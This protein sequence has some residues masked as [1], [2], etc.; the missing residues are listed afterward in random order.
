M[1]YK[2][3]KILLASISLFAMAIFCYLAYLNIFVF[4]TMPIYSDEYGYALDLKAFF[5]THTLIS[6]LTLDELYSKVGNFSFH[7]FTYTLIYA[8]L[9]YL[10]F[11][12]DILTINVILSLLSLFFILV[13]IKEVKL[14]WKLILIGTYI[15]YSI[16]FLY[17][18]SYMVE[19]THLFFGI[20]ITYL[21]YQVFTQ[22]RNNKYLIAFLAMVFLL[23]MLRITWLLFFIALLFI[24]YRSKKQLIYSLLF[25]LIASTLSLIHM[26]LFYAPYPAGF[27]HTLF[28][29]PHNIWTT[30]L[31]THTI[32]NFDLYMHR[33]T[34]LF[35]FLTKMLFLLLLGCGLFFGWYKNKKFLLAISMIALCYF[36]FLILF[37][38]A[39]SWRELRT[40][41]VVYCALLLAFALEKEYFILILML[42]IQSTT[43]LQVLSH[44]RDNRIDIYQKLTKTE[45]KE[46]PLIQIIQSLPTHQDNILITF[47]KKYFGFWGGLNF[48]ELLLH[49]PLITKEGTSIR[50]SISYF[51][52][53][54]PT[55]SQADF[56]FSHKN[57]PFLNK[58]FQYKDLY[59]YNLQENQ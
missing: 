30:A 11:T 21:L 53:F 51:N 37:Y 28:Q 20:I 57:Y 29:T 38:D 23:S 55:R 13:V 59:I 17:P 16:F 39:Y 19:E 47:D 40:L 41:G 56:L 3:L 2:Y 22:E 35:Y 10:F 26:Y 36:V 58:V 44:Y 45:K 9:G 52:S 5:T 25:M 14:F 24:P 48:N 6:P 31:M 18:F 50:Y 49:L 33:Y 8:L 27:I 32:N 15:T 12:Q 34:A 7:G 43:F 4:D 42:T 54:D 46:A 1:V